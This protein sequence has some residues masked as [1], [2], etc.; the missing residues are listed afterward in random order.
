MNTHRETEPTETHWAHWNCYTP[1]LSCLHFY[2]SANAHPNTPKVPTKNV[3]KKNPEK[4][5]SIRLWN[6]GNGGCL[7]GKKRGAERDREFIRHEWGF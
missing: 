6:W 7:R 4:L 1:R 2:H 5:T 3:P